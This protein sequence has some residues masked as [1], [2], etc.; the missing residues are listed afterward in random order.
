MAFELFLGPLV[1]FVLGAKFTLHKQEELIKN[2]KQAIEK[3]EVCYAE[4]MRVVNARLTEEMNRFNTRLTTMT[5]R[6]N[7]V[8]DGLET[9]S[10]TLETI[11]KQ[12]LQK[13][14]STLQPV[15]TAL[16]E[17]QTFVGLR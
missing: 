5:S 3:I 15:S 6:L 14:V 16:K 12:T 9:T 11:D 1:A 13:M 10:K 8:E 7:D 2:H 17:V 4:E